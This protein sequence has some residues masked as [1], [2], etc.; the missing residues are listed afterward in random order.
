MGKK[1]MALGCIVFY[2]FSNSWIAQKIGRSLEWRVPGPEKFEHVDGV[3]VLGGS[4]QAQILP[5]RTVEV[6]S[7]GDRL[8]FGGHLLQQGYADWIICSGGGLWEKGDVLSEAHSMKEMLMRLGVGEEQIILEP[9]SRNT[10][11]N[12]TKSL[13]LVVNQKA[14]SVYLVTSAS[15]MARSLAVFQKQAKIM[16]LTELEII[17]APCDFYHVHDPFPPP[18]YFVLLSSIVPSAEAL[19]ENT[20]YIHEYYGMLYY[21]LRGW[22]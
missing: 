14:K 3:I 16:N 8:L 13:P 12:A 9:K 2:L 5:R 21:K 6:A 19:Y 22:I 1:L 7:S 10:L 20:K 15:H 18:L 11:E 4:L 17:P